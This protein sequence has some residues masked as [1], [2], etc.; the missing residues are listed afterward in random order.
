MTHDRIVDGVRLSP[1]PPDR[2]ALVEIVNG[3]ERP[4]PREKYYV[5]GSILE[6]RIDNTQ[7]LAYGMNA[8]R[9][10]LLRREPG[11]PAACPR[12]REGREAGRVVR[13]ATPLRSGWAW[14][15]QYLDQAVSIVDAPVGKGHVVLFGNEVALARRSRTA[16]S[17]CCSTASTTGR[18][19]R[20]ARTRERPTSRRSCRS[21]RS[22]GLPRRSSKG[23]AS[24]GE[25]CAPWT[26]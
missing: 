4:L 14:G 21:G 3:T 18:P 26:M 13:D 1:R 12:R 2:N 20:P 16:R 7:P 5:P 19:R 24:E 10:G 6:A 8:A 25:K 15:Q 23:G 17:S 9:D 11:V 22:G